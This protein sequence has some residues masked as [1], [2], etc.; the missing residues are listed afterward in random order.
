M[1][2]GVTFGFPSIKKILLGETRTVGTTNWLIAFLALNYF[3]VD[4]SVPLAGNK[5]LFLY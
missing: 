4:N 3:P 1:M 2:T 5:L